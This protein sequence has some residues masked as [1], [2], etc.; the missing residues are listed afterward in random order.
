MISWSLGHL[1]AAFSSVS[2][3]LN[4]VA[5]GF[6]AWI[7]LGEALTA[8]QIGGGLAVLLG[9]FVARPRP[10]IPGPQPVLDRPQGGVQDAPPPKPV[11]PST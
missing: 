9:I 1:P 2:L 10:R 4:P 8:A 6:F 3:L 7:I 5:S 11:A